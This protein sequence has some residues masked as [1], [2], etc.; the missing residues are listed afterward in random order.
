MASF[1]RLENPSFSNYSLATRDLDEVV[2][3]VRAGMD[4][5]NV[6]QSVLYV[7]FPFILLWAQ[8]Y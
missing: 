6:L 1:G 4:T 7:L 3:G 5:L 2:K 8:Q